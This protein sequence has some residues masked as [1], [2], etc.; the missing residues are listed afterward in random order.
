[1]NRHCY[2]QSPFLDTNSD[3]ALLR[4]TVELKHDIL[5]QL[6]GW[7]IQPIDEQEFLKIPQ[8]QREAYILQKLNIN[9]SHQKQA[10]VAADKEQPS[11]GRKIRKPAKN[12]KKY[13]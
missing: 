11:G 10:D 5:D 4:R 9:Q 13:D 6:F 7:S 8:P 12:A 1:M 2:I 3:D